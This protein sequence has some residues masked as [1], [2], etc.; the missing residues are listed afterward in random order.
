MMDKLVCLT[1]VIKFVIKCQKLQRTFG[2]VVSFGEFI[3][4]CQD[5]KS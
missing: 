3:F 1:A 4:L 5:T 2:S